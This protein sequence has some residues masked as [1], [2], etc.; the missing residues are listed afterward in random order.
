[1]LTSYMENVW[2]IFRIFILCG[3]SGCLQ[4]HYRIVYLGRSFV[5]N[6]LMASF[7]VIGVDIPSDGFSCFLEISILREICF[8]IFEAAE[9]A[10]NHDIICPSAFALRSSA[11]FS[12]RLSSRLLSNARGAL[13]RNSF[14]QLR[15][16]SLTFFPFCSMVCHTTYDKETIFYD[17]LWR[18]TIKFDR[19]Q[20]LD[21]KHNRSKREKTPHS[22]L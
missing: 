5:P 10:F 9:P 4:K 3:C 18:I 2:S 20:S 21:Q 16:R 1:M 19:L 13:A 14:F 17:F 8:L 6:G 22:Y 11:S 12:R 15:R 7:K